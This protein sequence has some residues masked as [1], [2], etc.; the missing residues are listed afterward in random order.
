MSL[1]ETPTLFFASRPCALN[2]I[3]V[4][5]VDG[6]RLLTRMLRAPLLQDRKTHLANKEGCILMGFLE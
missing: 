5:N 3:A 4:I 1:K 6:A 2:V